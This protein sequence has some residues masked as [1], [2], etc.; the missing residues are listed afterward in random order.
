VIFLSPAVVLCWITRYRGPPALPHY[1]AGTVR[2]DCR[3]DRRADER[4]GRI[5]VYERALDQ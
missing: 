4:A 1:T 3:A 2:F 5:S